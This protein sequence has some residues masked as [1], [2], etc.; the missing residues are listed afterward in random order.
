MQELT[1]FR[2]FGSVLEPGC[3]RS[4]AVEHLLAKQEVEGSSP[5]ARSIFFKTRGRGTQV[6]REGSAK[7]RFVGSNPTR[8]S[9]FL[10]DLRKK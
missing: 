5:F 2:H 8:A 9:T 3:G 6:E 7:P 10:I 4:S 1:D